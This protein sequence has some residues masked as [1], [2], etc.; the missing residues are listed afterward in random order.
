MFKKLLKII[1]L[2]ILMSIMHIIANADEDYMLKT[3][4]KVPDIYVTKISPKHKIYDYMYII[5]RAND[6]AHVYC[7]EPGVSINSKALYNGINDISNSNLT[8]EQYEKIKIISY[9]GYGYKN[10]SIDHT[11]KKWYA[12]TQSLIWQIESNNHEIYFTDYLQGPKVDKFSNEYQE[13][14]NLI[15]SH[16]LLP[17]FNQDVIS[18]DLGNTITLNDINKVISNYNINVS[19]DNINVVK[20]NNEITISTNKIGTTTINFTK[21]YN[22][23]NSKPLLYTATNSQ[24]L[25]KVGNLTPTTTAITVNVTGAKITINKIDYETEKFET[26]SDASLIGA[27]YG[28]Y[29][30]NDNLLEELIITNNGSSTSSNILKLNETYYL[31]EIFPSTGYEI[32]KEKHYFTIKEKEINLTL[33]EQII[34]RKVIIKKYT[35][36]YEFIKSIPEKDIDF[37]IYLKSN[38]IL[39]ETITTNEDGIAS[40]T[41]PYGIYIFK[42]KNTNKYYNKVDDFEIIIDKVDKPIE[43]NLLNNI[44]SAKVK[45]IKI[46]GETNQLLPLSNIKFKIKNL[47]IDSYICEN[48]SCDFSTTNG[49]FTTKNPL[50]FGNYQLEETSEYIK[51]YQINKTPLKFTINDSSNFIKDNND[52]LIELKFIN[53]PSYGKLELTKIDFDNN[54]PLLN[55]LINVYDENNNLI[56]SGCTDI[57]GNIFV[58]KLRVGEYFYQ[59]IKPS[60][61][62]LLE[63]TIKKFTI[64]NHNEVIK[65][66]LT[67]KKE[68]EPPEIIKVPN[69]YKNDYYSNISLFFI[70]IGFIISRK[71]IKCSKK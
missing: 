16:N 11:D 8:K 21:N 54:L 12:V 51:G 10:E 56:Y 3:F 68:L 14:Q 22:N 67:N 6:K 71:T 55:T 63:N 1:L 36:N 7:V 59:E 60:P 9:Y 19:N 49:E 24:T 38:N 42:Q 4:D 27:K 61:G 34:K 29:D 57:N 40:I 25:F 46:D 32:D 50:Q 44:N 45:V 20:T 58:E 23:Y 30:I 53:L 65:E 62:Y 64:S 18:I 70:I 43:L 52:I 28:L 15:N 47:D 66:I 35:S 69:T 48:D 2:I 26:I 39:F 13:M 37:E 33:K 31:K 41:L 17:N 5:A